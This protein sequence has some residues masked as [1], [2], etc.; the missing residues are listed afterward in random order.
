MR[1]G[2]VRCCGELIAW[3]EPGTWVRCPRC[4]QMVTAKTV[5]RVPEWEPAASGKQR[6]GVVKHG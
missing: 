2:K 5:A 3:A 1:C 6:K 4:G